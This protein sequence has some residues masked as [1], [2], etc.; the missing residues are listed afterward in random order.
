MSPSSCCR[1]R[2]TSFNIATLLPDSGD[3]ERGA[4]ARVAGRATATNVLDGA[5]SNTPDGGLSR[6][7]TGAHMSSSALPQASSLW[8]ARLSFST[9]P[10]LAYSNNVRE[11]EEEEEERGTRGAGGLEHKRGAERRSPLGCDP[12]P[13]RLRIIK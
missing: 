11:G 2:R 5:L 3:G 12:L 7:E 10:A 13:Y 8:E 4:S 6:D 9:D 1:T